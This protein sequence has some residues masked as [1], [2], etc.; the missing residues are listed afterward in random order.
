MQACGGREGGW[1]VLEMDT[2]GF[3]AARPVLFHIPAADLLFQE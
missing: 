2:Q 3:M 1:G